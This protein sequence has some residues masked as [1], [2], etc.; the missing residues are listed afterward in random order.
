[1]PSLA[2]F[3][4]ENPYPVMRIDRAGTVLYANRLRH[5]A[6]SGEWR[7]RNRAAPLPEPLVPGSCE[8]RW[9]AGG[10]TKWTWRAA[11]R[12]LSFLVA[13]IAG[14]GYVNL[15]GRDI[16]DRK[17]AE[18]LRLSNAYNRSLLEASLDP[19]VTIGPDGK[20]RMS[21]PPPKR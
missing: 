6:L 5:R 15:Y 19:L 2:Q 18:A 3:P 14:G 12:V 16:T 4:D 1:M 20:S 21:T 9:T 8:K 13:P 17:R 10:P 11:G 7:C